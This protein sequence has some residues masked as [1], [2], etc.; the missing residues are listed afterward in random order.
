MFFVEEERHVRADN[1]FSFKSLRFEAPR[2]LPDRTIHIH[3]Q[4]S[5]PADR[6]IVYY[7][8]ERMGPARLLDPIANDRKPL[9]PPSTEI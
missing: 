9:N 4:R 1:T 2:H 5:S 6:V 3:F 8:G 7:K